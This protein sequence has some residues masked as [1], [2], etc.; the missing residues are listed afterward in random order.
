MQSWFSEAKT[1]PSLQAEV[2]FPIQETFY[3]GPDRSYDI[4][5]RERLAEKLIP[6]GIQ[7]A[8]PSLVRT[9]EALGQERE[10]AAY[11]QQIVR[12]A[13]HHKR[14][15]NSIRQYFWLRLWLWNTEH[16]VHV[17][18]PW[19][20]SLSEIDRFLAALVETESGLVDHDVDQGWELQ[21]YAHEGLIYFQQRD[22][23]ADETQLIVCVPRAGFVDHV[24]QLRER[25]K[26][27][28]AQLSSALGADVWTSFLGTEPAFKVERR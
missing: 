18:F 10:L 20:D 11:Y 19:Y 5:E 24:M 4:S 12:M 23:D 26:G 22:P 8:A 2:C 14:P 16:E 13:Q 3:Y 28:I 7:L 15:F 6:P 27:V 1:V 25:A 9:S 17:S 21:T